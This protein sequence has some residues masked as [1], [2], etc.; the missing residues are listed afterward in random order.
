MS[1]LI[2]PMEFFALPERA[3]GLI[4][5]I[6][7]IGQ[8][9]GQTENDGL[10]DPIIPI[11]QLKG[12]AEND[13]KTLCA[14]N[15][16]A[17]MV[18][19]PVEVDLLSNAVHSLPN[20]AQVQLPQSLEQKDEP[21]QYNLSRGVEAKVTAYDT[22][23]KL[24]K[25][26]PLLI[27]GSCLYMYNGIYYQR[28][29]PSEAQRL[30]VEKCRKDVEQAGTPNLP[31]AVYDFLLME[32]EL[33]RRGFNVN[34]KVVSFLNGVLQL[35]TYE[36][37]QNNPIWI[38]TYCIQC[39]YLGGNPIS[40]RFDLFLNQITGGDT[41]LIERIWQMI[42]YVLTPDTSGKA[43]FLL[44]GVS[45]SGKSVLSALLSSFFNEDAISALDVHVLN[46]K[47]AVSELQGKAL[48]ISP[49]LP[50]GPLDNKAVSKLKQLTGNDVVSAD[51]KYKDRVQFRCTAKIVL[52]SNHPLLIREPDDAFIERVVV[53]PFNYA[54]QKEYQDP[55]LLENL[56]TERDAI[57]TKAIAAYFRLV[58][59]KYQFSGNY[60]LNSSAVLYT[61]NNSAGIDL[62][63]SVYNF[64]RLNFVQDTETEVFTED[65]H[66]LFVEQYGAVSIN[67]FSS[68]FSEL[69]QQLYG[70][71]KIR[72]RK[73]VGTNPL[74]C[75][76]G[77]RLIMGE[78]A[79]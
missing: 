46:E 10:I 3:D 75:V 18:L 1:E 55:H 35:D 68:I 37:K 42:G 8:L 56:K 12:Q 50:S 65:A 53:V 60:I 57:A 64:L 5:P 73:Q 23:K 39:R 51:V 30:I 78:E 31:R 21:A 43:F 38:T 26:V 6:I 66:C 79:E 62:P 34:Q 9:R 25:Q 22:A 76:E 48:C 29:T 33:A 63:A 74:S 67:A 40:P 20:I 49:D 7:P 45:N 32:P 13:G 59:Q 44:Q 69:A 24:M 17:G 54:T 14:V 16:T 36:L 11:G 72:K 61:Q 47:F 4:D 2:E 27:I 71:E 77:I 19:K 15:L 58:G 70:A 28:L 52:A 41:L